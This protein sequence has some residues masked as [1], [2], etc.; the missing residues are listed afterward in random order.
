MATA[1]GRRWTG[2]PRY[3]FLWDV[4]VFGI[5][6]VIVAAVILLMCAMLWAVA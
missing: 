1:D 5:W 4:L 2:R 6:F 3:A